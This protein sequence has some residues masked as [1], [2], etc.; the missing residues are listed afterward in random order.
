LNSEYSFLQCVV[1][2]SGGCGS[3]FDVLI[4]S[5]K[6]DGVPLLQRQRSVNTALAALMSSI[7]ALTMK[8]LTPA[9]YTKR[10]ETLRVEFQ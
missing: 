9:E 3:S 4:V 5:A 1:D 10:R 6:F 2:V 8:A 7:H